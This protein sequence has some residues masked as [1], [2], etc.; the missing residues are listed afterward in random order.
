MSGDA[1]SVVMVSAGW[2][3]ALGGA[4]RQAEEQARALAARG[5]RVTALTRRLPGTAAEE[6]R[7]GVRVRRLPSLGS[8]TL[9]SLL[10]LAEAF[11]W[12]LLHRHE[13]DAVHAH[14]AGS[15]ALAAAAAGR[16][17]GKPVLVKLGG[18][19]GIGEL[20]VSSR[21]VFGRLKLR[22]LASLRP[23]FLA[24]VPDLAEEAAEHLGAV[25]VEVLPNGVDTR[26]F[27]PAD[28]MRK[29]LVRASLGLP[30]D[31][32]IFLYTGRFSPE[33]RLAWFAGLWA[34]ATEGTGAVFVLAGGGGDA[35]AASPRVVLLPAVEDSAPLYAAADVFVLP[36]ASEG[37]S[38]S[39]LEAMSAG[40]PALAS[41]V[42]GTAQTVEDGVT[43]LLFAREDAA[44]AK[45]A[46]GRLAREPELRARLGAAA[47]RAAV[48]RYGLDGVVERLEALYRP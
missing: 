47:R 34:E 42:G 6:E 22:L 40:L 17:L 5:A 21:S 46:A 38:N 26:R 48:E 1:S 3:P 29:R 27:V 13:Y 16:L 8:G 23:R 2:R 39:L 37:L 35:P 45:A 18:G 33:K 15:P 11:V 19:R 32:P 31:A 41:A 20:A 4:E 36:S 25:P 28:A 7:D 44:A 30:A 14:L 10:F 43:G 24:V 12:L 9:D